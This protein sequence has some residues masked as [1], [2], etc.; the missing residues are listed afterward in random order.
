MA[1]TDLESMKG[2][3]FAGGAYCDL[4]CSRVHWLDHVWHPAFLFPAT[5]NKTCSEENISLIR[6]AWGVSVC[7]ENKT[8][9]HS[10]ERRWQ[11]DTIYSGQRKHWRSR[12]KTGSYIR[13]PFC[14]ES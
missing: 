10:I 11:E 8:G 9:L 13:T 2:F 3:I 12:Y 7:V 14:S 1:T 6:F 4:V 5:I